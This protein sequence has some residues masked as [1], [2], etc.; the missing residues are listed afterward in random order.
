[1][2]NSSSSGGKN[3]SKQKYTSARDDEIVS[4]EKR[5]SKETPA[6]GYAPPL[7]QKVEFRSLAIS[8]AT[9]QGLTEGEGGGKR[10]KNPDGSDCKTFTVMTDIQNACIP[11]ALAGRDILGAAKTGTFPDLY[12]SSYLLFLP[13]TKKKTWTTF[14]LS[15]RVC[16]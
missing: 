1:M 6:R 7:G 14:L 3:K 4:L 8:E 15:L 2:V 9:L 10:K 11:H 5:I 13:F 16:S 12:Y